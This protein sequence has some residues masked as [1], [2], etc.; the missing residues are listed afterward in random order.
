[1]AGLADEYTLS[2]DQIFQSRVAMAAVRK[3]VAIAG[4]TSAGLSPARKRLAVLI[5]KDAI[6]ESK[7]LCVVLA[8]DTVIAAKAPTQASVTDAE[9]THCS[10]RRRLG[11]LRP[12]LRL[13]CAASF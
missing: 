5:L 6:Q 11:C 3:A 2:Q 12:S 1:M 7:G 10:Q 13:R 4:E 8:R 9:V